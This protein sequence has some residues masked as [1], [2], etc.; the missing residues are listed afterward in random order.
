MLVTTPSFHEADGDSSREKRDGEFRA[1]LAVTS[2]PATA[3]DTAAGA[4]AAVA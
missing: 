2:P 4:A 3:I 1:H